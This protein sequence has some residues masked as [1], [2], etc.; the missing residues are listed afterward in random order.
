MDFTPVKVRQDFPKDQVDDVK[1]L[2]TSELKA[3]DSFAKIEQGMKVAVLA[4]SRGIM[5]IGPIVRTVVDEIKKAGGEPSVVAAMGSHG[6]G[7]AEGQREVLHHLGISEETMDCPIVCS[8]ESVLVGTTLEGYPVYVNRPVLEFDGILAINR[9]KPHTAFKGEIES[10][11]LKM[12]SVGLG[13]PA[14]AAAVHGQGAKGLRLMVPS[15]GK[16]VKKRLP[17]LGGLA[18]VE[19]AYEKT[20]R[21]TGVGNADLEETEKGLLVLAKQLMPSLP[22]SEIDVLVVE[23]MGKNFSGTGMDSNVLNRMRIHGEPE[24]AGLAIKRIVVLD[25][26][27]ASQGNATGIGLADFTT[28]ALVEKI[29][30]RATYL[31]CLTS[32]FVQRAMIPVIMEDEEQAI[33]AAI[34]S[35]GNVSAE[36]SRLVRIANTLSLDFLRVSENLIPEVNAHPR[37]EIIE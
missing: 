24:P 34:K 4:G 18:I 36:Q 37:L 2:V 21:I 29:D 23:E 26:S 17:F 19:N 11:I 5:N 12:L 13:G 8:G 16:E 35:L 6:G 20:Y 22:F 7:T 27:D 9:I 33:R 3:T 30:Y 28:E 31:N 1:S 14:G 32:T 25:L 15:I 10:G